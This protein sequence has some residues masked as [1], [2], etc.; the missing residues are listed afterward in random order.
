MKS[1]HSILKNSRQKRFQQQQKRYLVVLVVFLFVVA[2]LVGLFAWLSGHERF[3][4]R[5]IN[6]DGNS[7]VQTDD[8][9]SVV[10]EE[11]SGKYLFLFTKQNTFIYPKDTIENRLLNEFKRIKDLDIKRKNFTALEIYITEY[12]PKYLWCSEYV[13]DDESNINENC[14]FM[15]KDGYVYAK[16]P[17]FSGNI[18]FEWYTKSSSAEPIGS[19]MLDGDTFSKL[20]TFIDV[21]GNIG[22][23]LIQITQQEEGDYTLVSDS[24]SKILFNIDQDSAVLVDTLDSVLDEIEKDGALDY[25]DLRFGNKVFFKASE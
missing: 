14:Y 7:V 5:N 9:L 11:A 12:T 10:D 2:L 13:E 25:I 3:L 15:N 21:V 22:F 4:V 16:A 8:V 17:S 24:G 6:V 20:V 1:R 23:D 19:L 18:F